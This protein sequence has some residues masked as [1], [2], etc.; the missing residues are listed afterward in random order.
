MNHLTFY[1]YCYGLYFKKNMYRHTA[2]CGTDMSCMSRFAAKSVRK[3]VDIMI[4]GS[5]NV[6]PEVLTAFHEMCARMRQ[7]IVTSAIKTEKLMV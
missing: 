4:A 6:M 1:P 7:D 2:S 3:T 5:I